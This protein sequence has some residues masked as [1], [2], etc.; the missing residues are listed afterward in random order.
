MKNKYEP[1]HLRS[2]NSEDMIIPD[3]GS[4]ESDNNANIRRG[5]HPAAVP[6]PDSGDGAQY[7]PLPDGT[8]VAANGAIVR[9]PWSNDFEI[10]PDNEYTEEKE[11]LNLLIL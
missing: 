7:I 4:A 5:V 1:K 11:D 8:N 9:N 6:L 2:D 10:K 3:L